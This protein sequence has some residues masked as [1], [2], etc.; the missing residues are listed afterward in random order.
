MAKI[1][2]VISDIGDIKVDIGSIQ[3]NIMAIH[4]DL[5]ERK[6]DAKN[7]TAKVDRNSGDIIKL[8]TKNNSVQEIKKDINQKS[9]RNYILYGALIGLG[10]A[11]IASIIIKFL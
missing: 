1:D 4:E 2:Q 3:T 10:G 6:N 7:I 8:K 9:G 11:V 5:T